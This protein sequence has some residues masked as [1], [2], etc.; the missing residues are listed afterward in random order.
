MSLGGFI[1][2][3]DIP[4]VKGGCS[5]SLNKKPSML[6][7]LE[8]SDSCTIKSLQG[9]FLGGSGCKCNLKK[10]KFMGGN[11]WHFCSNDCK[12]KLL[13]N[14]LLNDFKGGDIQYKIRSLTP[15]HTFNDGLNYLWKKTN[16]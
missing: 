8:C 5:C 3:T 2:F 11:D 12:V 10:I 9:G 7:G 1:K 6:G 15:T 16:F 13:M 4:F 14:N